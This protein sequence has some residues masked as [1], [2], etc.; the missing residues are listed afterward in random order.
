MKNFVKRI[1]A[2]ILT[3]SLIPV[4]N[5]GSLY[6]NG[7]TIS[8]LAI[9]QPGNVYIQLSNMNALVGICSLDTN[10]APA[11]SL[12]GVT[13]PAACKAMLAALMIAKQTGAAIPQMLFDGDKVPTSCTGF[14]YWEGVN[15]RFY[16]M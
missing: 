10:W 14:T 5:A 6:C 4:A 16:L 15:V 3:I 12:S 9:H 13:T 11:G 2:V 1:T 8:Y 7:A